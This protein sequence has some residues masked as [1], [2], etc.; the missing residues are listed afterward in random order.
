MRCR[1]LSTRSKVI[2]PDTVSST[3]ILTIHCT[4]SKVRAQD[5]VGRGCRKKKDSDVLSQNVEVE[6]RCDGISGNWVVTAHEP[7]L[8]SAR[9]RESQERE[10]GMAPCEFVQVRGRAVKVS[11]NAAGRR[12][13]REDKLCRD[14]EERKS[15]VSRLRF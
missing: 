3:H 14:D 9:S 5:V 12:D 11:D 6:E 15:R 4:W 8:R 7:K 1:A 13:E 10:G 2:L